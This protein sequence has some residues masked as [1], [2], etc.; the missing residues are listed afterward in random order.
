MYTYIIMFRIRVIL[1]LIYTIELYFQDSVHSSFHVH[2][3]CTR[4][5]LIY[6][7]GVSSKHDRY[8]ELITRVGQ[9]N[10]SSTIPVLG[11]LKN[12]Y[13]VTE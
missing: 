7:S 6:N 9:D 4:P 8:S 1:K 11:M 12:P 2:V 10:D 3:K 13:I 5:T